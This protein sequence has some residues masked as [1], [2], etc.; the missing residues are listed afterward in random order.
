MS[1]LE[2]VVNKVLLNIGCKPNTLTSSYEAL[3]ILSGYHKMY[4]DMLT[5]ITLQE[6]TQPETKSL[7]RTNTCIFSD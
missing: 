7:R 3:S 1:C 6:E 5:Q 2:Y 4:A